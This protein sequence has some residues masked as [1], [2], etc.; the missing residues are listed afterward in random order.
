METPKQIEIQHSKLKLTLMFLGSIIFV[1]LGI[2]FVTIPTE[3]D[4]LILA[5]PTLL[6]VVGF[7]SILFFGFVGFSILK[8]LGDKSPGL[9]ISEEGV[10]DNSSGVS[11]GFIPWTDILEIKE[12]K[13]VNQKFINLV[14]KNPQEYIDRQQSLFKRKAMQINHNSYGTVIGI[15]ANGLKSNYKGLKLLIDNKFEEYK[16]RTA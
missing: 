7:A 12:T 15:S 5:S 1:G 6:F 13:V 8:K 9:I 16:N 4:N 10:V 14:V 11:V 3:T 2:W